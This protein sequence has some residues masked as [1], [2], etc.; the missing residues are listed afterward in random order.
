MRAGCDTVFTGWS[1]LED[2]SSGHGEI[3]LYELT[4][5]SKDYKGTLA[6]NC[7]NDL[8][9]FEYSI[10][11]PA[12]HDTASAIAMSVLIQK[13]SATAKAHMLAGHASGR[14]LDSWKMQEGNGNEVLADLHC[15]CTIC[16]ESKP[17]PHL[18]HNLKEN[19]L[20]CPRSQVNIW[21]LPIH[22]FQMPWMP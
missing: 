4:G 1:L 5:K 6:L 15:P 17:K 7:W 3:S 19:V 18:W 9:F 22:I 8:W 21:Y 2:K 12:R 13:Q 14:R 10:S 20:P 11:S 16:T